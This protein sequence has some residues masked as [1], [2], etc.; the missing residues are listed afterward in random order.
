MRYLLIWWIVNPGHSQVI[1]MEK[2]QSYEACA[3]ELKT[4]PVP[5]GRTLRANC[6]TE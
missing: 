5:P 6:S 2:Y 1:H 4:I 3:H